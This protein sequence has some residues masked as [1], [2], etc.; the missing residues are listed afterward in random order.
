MQTKLKIKIPSDNICAGSE[1]ANG[2]CA[3]QKS[4]KW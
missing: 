1:K 2:I 3:M 4:G